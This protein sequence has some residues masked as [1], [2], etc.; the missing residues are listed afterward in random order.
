MKEA[1]LDLLK[2]FTQARDAD[3]F[4]QIVE[5][6]QDSVYSTCV[7]VLD[8]PA[9]A[10]DA[11]QECFLRL[12]QKADTVRSSLAGW[13]H[14]CATNMSIDEM[15]GRALRKRTEEVNAKMNAAS[16]NDP[17]WHELAPHVDKALDEL[18]E[19]LRIAI[20]E[21][22]LQRRTQAEIAE[23]LGVSAMTVSRR[24]ES[25]IEELSKN[26]KKAG[27]IV[28]A[29]LLASLI[30][31]NAVQAAPAALTAALSKMSVLAATKS[32]G[33]VSSAGWVGVGTAPKAAAAGAKTKLLIGALAAV[34]VGV[35][36]LHL[37]TKGNGQ[38]PAQPQPA[39]VADKP[40]EQ[41]AAPQLDPL[42]AAIPAD[43]VVFWWAPNLRQLA[44]RAAALMPLYRTV[45][46]DVVA[47]K[48]PKLGVT[49]DVLD[50]PAAVVMMSLGQPPLDPRMVGLFSVKDMDAVIATMESGPDANGMYSRLLL[51]PSTEEEPAIYEV[52]M[53][54]YKG[55][56]AFSDKKRNLQ[57]LADADEKAYEPSAEALRLIDDAQAFLHIDAA[58]VRQMIGLDTAPQG[59]VVAFWA[60]PV[61]EANSVDL[62]FTVD[63][64]GVNLRAAV[65]VKDDSK[66]V[67]YLV[68]ARGLDKL[69]PRLPLL[70]N[71]AAAAWVK[72]DKKVAA[73]LISNL[74]HGV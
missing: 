9:G 39:A 52:N 11:S 70:P 24:V 74:M 4:S 33:A 66:V 10:E 64:A 8:D 28:S 20:V 18:P 55:F 60:L 12:L 27:L 45:L 17:T 43:A 41:P 31:E 72:G 26:F 49:N 16:R 51:R 42:L 47:N 14:R 53:M 40:E 32:G 65:A 62:S 23:Q 71:Y 29:A 7:R 19:H 48:L 21:H 54:P 46:D 50:G 56:A 57:A 68:P 6:Y 67:E 25:G 58:T 5:R 38:P 2:R 36:A 22:L 44:D 59:V 30:S 15:R 13:L 63:D 1:D 73:R 3:A 37:A 69:E 61:R 35:G 34:A